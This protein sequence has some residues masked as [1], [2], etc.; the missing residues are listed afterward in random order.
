MPG[1]GR[2]IEKEPRSQWLRAAVTGPGRGSDEGDGLAS[3]G[4]PTT[5]L[6]P[7]LPLL[8]PIAGKRVSDWCFPG[9]GLPERLGAGAPARALLGLAGAR[10]GAGDAPPSARAIPNSD[11][12]ISRV[13]RPGRP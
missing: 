2:R 13:R 10:P 5:R 12:F 8:A 1:R 7:R 3:G 4:P 11:G 9:D 6:L